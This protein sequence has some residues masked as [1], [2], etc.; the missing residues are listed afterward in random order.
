MKFLCINPLP[1]Y[2]SPILSTAAKVSLSGETAKQIEEK[3]ER[4]GKEKRI[5]AYKLG[6]SDRHTKIPGTG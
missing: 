5:R 1:I 2:N 3:V 4:K 6:Q